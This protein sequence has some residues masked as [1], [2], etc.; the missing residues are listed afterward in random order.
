MAGI[1]IT[2][3]IL[4]LVVSSFIYACSSG[5]KS[6]VAEPDLNKDRKEILVHLADN[7][8]I[9]SYTKFK[10]KFDVMSAKSQSFVST[11]NVTTLTEY[12]QAWVDAYNEWQKVEVF[13]FGP[14]NR[15]AIRG[16]Y[17]IYPTNV[18]GIARYINDPSESLEVVGSYDKQ[19]FPALDYLLNGVGT[20]DAEIVAWYQAPTDGPKRLAFIK[21]IN[22]HMDQLITKVILEWRGGYYSDFTTKTGTDIGSPMGE[23]VNN[24]VLHYERYIRSGKF[25]IPS[26]AMLNGV[27]AADKVEAFYKK[28]ISKTLAQVAHQS[29]IDFFNGKNIKT[30]ENGPSFRSY[31][32]ALNAKDKTSGKYLSEI[33]NTQFSASQNKMNGLLPN[34]NQQVLTNNQLMK[35]VYTDLQVAVRML[36]VD[37]TSAMSITI[38]YTDN[39]GD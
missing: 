37:M 19:G 38:T 4:F 26:G 14:A 11:P 10:E 21:R 16:S 6:N 30:G 9:P 17:N 34:L 23:M 20:T 12:R 39:D 33:I 18:Q 8:I 35:D 2:N 27:V 5:D 3:R 36:K 13:D 29:A 32:D 25:G 24:F 28:D 7:V 31:L 1:Q 22:S 15:N